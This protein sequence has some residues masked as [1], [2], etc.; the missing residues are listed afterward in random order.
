M[1]HTMAIDL[2]G[3][4]DD[5]REWVWATKPDDPDLRESVNVWAWDES[6]E[7]GMPRVGV[8]AAGNQWE[9]HDNQVNI[10]FADG[11]VLNIFAPGKVHDPI[12]ADGKPRILGAGPLAFELIE[13]Y[14]HWRLR[15][16]GVATVT[17]TQDQIEGWQ[18]GEGKGETVPVKLDLEVKSA[19]PPWEQ[20]SLLEEARRVMET[21]EEGDLIGGPRF[22]QLFRTT[23]TLRVGD[24]E[25]YE[26]NGGGLR[27]RRTGI[28]RLTAFPGHIWQSSL[29][30]SGRAFG[31]L[32]YPPRKDGK[33]TY[34]E[35]F[36]FEGDGKLIPAT[37]VKAPWL[38]DLEP[39]GQDATVVLKTQDGATHT[40]RGE[41]ILSTFMVIGPRI[42]DWNLQ[43]DQG[44]PSFALQQAIVRY[45]W[46]GEV[47]NG[48]MERSRVT[49]QTT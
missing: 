36:I 42:A 12:G 24:D 2:T 3:G 40:I 35:G 23:G 30:P 5:E 44:T 16:D 47:A 9:T 18:A 25:T 8:E 31:L 17:S 34:N 49:D 46:D 29:F 22:E 7:L 33:P 28:R 32:T 21:Q 20:G 39:K 26:I 15:L 14:H 13:P 11:R 1:E 6:G 4:L 41:T 45:S 37:V 19:V 38:R 10:A 48:M 27:I 43:A